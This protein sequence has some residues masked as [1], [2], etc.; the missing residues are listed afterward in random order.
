MCVLGEGQGSWRFQANQSR[1]RV[2]WQDPDHRF[3][4]HEWE[5]GG[6]VGSCEYIMWFRSSLF[7]FYNQVTHK[8]VLFVVAE[9][10]WWALDPAG[11]GHQQWSALTFLWPWH[12]CSLPLRQGKELTRVLRSCRVVC[13]WSYMLNSVYGLTGWQQHQILWGDRRGSIRPLSLHVQQ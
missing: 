6:A 7:Q 5:A 8:S 10:L 3:Q 2:W 1:V 12:W 11:A 4:P 9:Q 13:S